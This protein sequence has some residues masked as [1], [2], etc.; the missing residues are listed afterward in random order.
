MDVKIGAAGALRCYRTGRTALSRSQPPPPSQAASIMLSA[1]AVQVVR[2]IWGYLA[3]MLRLQGATYC[4]RWT[5][6]KSYSWPWVVPEVSA[7]KHQSQQGEGGKLSC[8][9]D[10]GCRIAVVAG[11]L[12]RP[13]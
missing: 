10:D 1:I 8:G 9:S 4:T 6:E 7:K 12:S 13:D 3:A 11:T 2:R 5:M